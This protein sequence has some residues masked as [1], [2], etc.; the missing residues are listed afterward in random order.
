MKSEE[1][2][3]ENIYFLLF[4]FLSHNFDL[5]CIFICIY[6]QSILSNERLFLYRFA[7][8]IDVPRISHE[9]ALYL[10]YLVEYDRP[11]WKFTLGEIRFFQIEFDQITQMSN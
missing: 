6:T 2:D 8:Y 4:M 10:I 9:R 3:K 11:S 5:M 7:F 1:T